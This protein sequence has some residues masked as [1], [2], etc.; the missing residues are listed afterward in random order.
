MSGGLGGQPVDG[1]VV[2]SLAFVPEDSLLLRPREEIELAVAVKPAGFHRVHF[3]LISN[4]ESFDGF[5]ESASAVTNRD[6]IVWERLTAPSSA[7]SFQVRASVADGLFVERTVSVGEEGFATVIA[8]P[9]YPGERD[10]SSWTASAQPQTSC[11]KLE[12]WWED[13]PL[14]ATSKTEVRLT[15]LPA[16]Q[17]AAV[18]IR[19]G[20]YVG[21][22]ATVRNLEA[23]EIRYVTV[24][25]KDR[26]LQLVGAEIPLSLSLTDKTTA[27]LAVLESAALTAQAN[28]APEKSEA[29][30]LLDDMIAQIP[31]SEEKAAFA[32]NQTDTDLLTQVTWH[33]QNRTLP[34][35]AI[36]D[37]LLAAIGRLDGPDSFVFQLENDVD[38][39]TLV[40]ES[41]GG[42][43]AADSG[44]LGSTSVSLDTQPGDQ[45]VLGG[46]V[47]FDA[48]TFLAASAERYQAAAGAGVLQV[49]LSAKVGCADLGASLVA[50]LGGPLYGSCEAEC[51][52]ALCEAA[53]GAGW[54]R[55]ASSGSTLTTLRVGITAKA[56]ID[57][58]ARPVELL[59]T[60]VGSLDSSGASV[61]GAVSGGSGS[62]GLDPAQEEE[63][64]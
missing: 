5:L 22:C 42:V 48:T 13:G 49:T 43:P 36:R 18:V 11:D 9:Q 64:P 2:E 15:S 61:A 53:L 12:S 40:L 52:Q 41:A 33:L 50:E 51:A 21:G 37:E 26:P 38:G 34:S 20:R 14:M 55:A 39:A 45:V 31:S 60:W 24:T 17:E 63:A 28:Y 16:G 10:V 62:L 29:A 6:G 19:A 32:E 56:R 8:K 58:E 57:D 4:S 25:T 47:A 1:P 44:F 59:G 54:Q 30:Q 23:N 35:L 46:D 3:S 7:G 27:F